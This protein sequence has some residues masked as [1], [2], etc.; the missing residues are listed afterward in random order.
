MSTTSLFNDNRQ[1]I[2]CQGSSPPD[3][4]ALCHPKASSL[5]CALLIRIAMTDDVYSKNEFLKLTLEN[6]GHEKKMQNHLSD[7]ILLLRNE[8]LSSQNGNHR[9]HDRV[10][11]AILH[12]LKNINLFSFINACS[13]KLYPHRCPLYEAQAAALREELVERKGT[14]KKPLTKIMKFSNLTSSQSVVRFWLRVALT[15][16]VWQQ[17]S[18]ADKRRKEKEVLLSCL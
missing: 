12:N 3:S 18:A 8:D 10:T 5:H 2:A 4:P 7:Y 6:D 17:P 11:D 14:V 13:C 16:V 1:S 15:K 9:H